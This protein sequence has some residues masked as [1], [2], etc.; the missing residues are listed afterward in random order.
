[1]SEVQRIIKYLAIAFALFLAVSIVSGIMYGFIRVATIFNKDNEVSKSVENIK[2][3]EDITYLDID[4]DDVN[5]IIKEGD[6]LELETNSKY[7]KTKEDNKKLYIEQKENNWFN[8]EKTADL[9]IYLPKDFEFNDIS[10]EAGAG[11]IEIEKL[12]TNKLEL[13]LGAGKVNVNN[14][15]VLNKTKIDGGAGEVIINNGILND[16]DLEMG[17]GKFTLT[18]KLVGNSMI[19]H[20]V[21]ELNLNLVGNKEDYQIYLDEGLGDVKVNGDKVYNNET[22]GNGNNKIDIDGGI[23]SITIDFIKEVK[24]N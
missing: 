18:A 15:E 11:K 24:N 19:D 22:I 13:D 2:I 20:G 16:L 10:I 4:V 5:I 3:S 7:L 6:K 17:V 14:I 21:G 9:I 23:G 12:I 8:K 1:M